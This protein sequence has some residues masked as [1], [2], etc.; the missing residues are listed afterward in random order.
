MRKSRV[1]R[2]AKRSF[3]QLART[4]SRELFFA[5][6]GGRYA[7]KSLLQDIPDVEGISFWQ[8]FG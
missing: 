6:E 5:N 7:L 3:L 4:L 8:V 1:L 2:R